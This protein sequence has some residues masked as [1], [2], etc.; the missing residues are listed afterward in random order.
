MSI[1]V[2]LIIPVYNREHLL[3]KAIESVLAQTYPYFE[4]LVWDDGSS[5]NS[6]AI[7]QHYAQRDR[8][9]RVVAAPH[10]G[11]AASHNAAIAQTQGQY[12]GYLDS[13]DILDP[14]ALAQTVL[15]LAQTEIGVVY[16]DYIAIDATGQ[17]RQYGTR[18]QI[19]YSK[20]ALLTSFMTFHFRLMRRHLFEQVEGMDES[21]Q[22]SV[23]Y[24]LCMK[25]SEVTEFLHLAKPLYYYR[26]HGGNISHDYQ[27]RYQQIMC[28]RTAILNAMAR[29]GLQEQYDLDIQIEC[30]A[31]LRLKQ[32]EEQLLYCK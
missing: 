25:L 19:P 13:D 1:K 10:R 24:D 2:S 11:I 16:T 5:D 17:R 14:Q 9:V 21:L 22:Y 7:A 4:L 30:R 27:K 32:P 28:S 6:V 29:R 26:S 20:E 3:G 15:I 23:D 8:R 12:I 31:I 18:C